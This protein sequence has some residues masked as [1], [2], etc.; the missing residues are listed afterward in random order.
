M[1][2]ENFNAGP[3][4]QRRRL[5][6]S[7]LLHTLRKHL[8]LIVACA[9][10]GLIL[11]IILSVVPY[12][13]GEM[14]KQY[15][16]KSSIAVTSQNESGMFTAQSKDPNSSDIYLAEEMVDAVIYVMKS[17]RTLQA[18]V[19]RLELSGISTKDISN[20]LILSQYN[21]TQ[22]V[23]MTLYWRSAQ[24]GVEILAAINQVAPGIL[25]DTLKIGNVAVINDPTAQYLIGGGVNATMWGYMTI[26]GLL[27]GVGFAALELLLRPTLL[28]CG[29]MESVFAVE[30]LGQI[31]DRK[32]FFRKM[33]NPFS[34]PEDEA[35]GAEVRDNYLSAAYLLKN[36]IQ[37]MEHPCVYV[38]SSIRSEGRTT[39][40][41]NLAVQL[42]DIG[43]HVLVVDLDTRNPKL[44]GLFLN[45]AA[46]QNSINALY[47]GDAAKEAAITRLTDSL[48]ILPALPEPGPIPPDE[49][50]REIIAGLREDYDVILMDTA[51]VGQ[52]ADTMGLNQLADAALLVVRFDC[53]SMELI[54]D[55]ITRVERSGM[56]ILGCIVNGTR[57]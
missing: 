19:D 43:L 13:R 8:P 44:G 3:E 25:V 48:D 15:A 31:P 57:V 34:V 17:N 47:R 52:A 4:Q 14:R 5:R 50:L 37:K 33:R 40:T 21:D 51:P 46:Y 39:V 56:Q 2:G 32:D 26:L 6:L 29:D 38:T 49:A 9:A 27:L 24:E 53:A 42:S 18:A 16:I 35:H 23:E 7:D 12:L 11:G 54:R 30:V 20:N 41:A 22:I 10:V 1:N 55:S 45:K 36:R 28:N